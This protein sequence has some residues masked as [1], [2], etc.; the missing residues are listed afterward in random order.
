MVCA[1]IYV[2]AGS[3]RKYSCDAPGV[4][5]TVHHEVGTSPFVQTYTDAYT[6]PRTPSPPPHPEHPLALKWV[7]AH[8][9]IAI[10]TAPLMQERLRDHIHHHL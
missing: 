8:L 5:I 7:P 6:D 2:S 9:E 4:S 1:S 10:L 3:L